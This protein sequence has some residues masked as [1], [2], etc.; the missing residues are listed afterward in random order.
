MGWETI[1]NPDVTRS[2]PALAL[3]TFV[4]IIC[5]DIS[6]GFRDANVFEI[7]IANYGDIGENKKR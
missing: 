5:S 6:C 4:Y 1:P 2:E 7:A 3:P